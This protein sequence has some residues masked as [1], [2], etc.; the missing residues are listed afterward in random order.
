MTR[1]RKP[2][3]SLSAAVYAR[4]SAYADAAGI[5]RPVALEAAIGYVPA[6]GDTDVVDLEI[7]DEIYQR[8]APVARRSVRSISSVVDRAINAALDDGER[9][10]TTIPRRRSPRVSHAHTARTR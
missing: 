9:Y 2:Q 1:P 5:S 4:L 6:G 7:S 8:A 10:P 3:I